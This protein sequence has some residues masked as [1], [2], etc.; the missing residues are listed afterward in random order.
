VLAGLDPLL[1]SL[2]QSTD[3]QN[4]DFR[5]QLMG[6]LVLAAAL[7]LLVPPYLG[8]GAFWAAA[9]ALAVQ[10]VLRLRAIGRR[11]SIALPWRRL[12]S[13]A[14]LAAATLVLLQ[15]ATRGWSQPARLFG[16][17]ALPTAFGLV[18]WLLGGMRLGAWLR[19]LAKPI[20]PDDALDDAR[21]PHTLRTIAADLRARDA[22]FA[23][24]LQNHGAS[25]VV[26]YRIARWLTLNGH[27]FLG[28]LVWQLNLLVSKA[29]LPPSTR[30]GPG[31]VVTHSVGLIAVGQAGA[32]LTMRAWSAFGVRGRSNAGAGQGMPNIGDGVTFDVRSALHGGLR[33]DGG[34][35]FPAHLI[36][37]TG[38]RLAALAPSEQEAA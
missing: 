36:V 17:V 22:C 2:L 24:T 35:Q 34:T 8:W 18:A 12:L 20:Q 25:A 38:R 10:A 14:L 26:L 7:A 32:N 15:A 23:G 5:A 3:G 11:L 27:R 13:M 37:V 16:V 9:G 31:F 30:I 6:T 21:L 4:E 1:T 28:R 29:E 19:A 33:C